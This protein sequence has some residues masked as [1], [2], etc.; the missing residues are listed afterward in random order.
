[1]A[2]FL[3]ELYVPDCGEGERAA[4]AARASAAADEL[5][6][7]GVPVRHLR[8]AFVPSDETCFCFFEAPSANWAREAVIRAALEAVSVVETYISGGGE[9]AL[10]GAA[11]VEPSS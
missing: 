3:A 7:E 2:T 4:L 9:T 10:G 5:S 1:M 11:L 8:S 6:R